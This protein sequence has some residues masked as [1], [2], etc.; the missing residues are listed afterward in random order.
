MTELP[1]GFRASGLA[2]GIKRNGAADLGLIALE[3]ARPAAA[4]FTTNALLGAHVPV[5]RE[6]LASSGGLVRAILVNSGNANCA[7]GAEGLDDAILC[8]ATVA[9]RLGCPVEQVLPIS[10]G[11]IGARL[12]TD[13]ITTA[14]PRLVD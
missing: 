6:H 10:T 3:E 5:C 13:R 1:S 4:V 7:V 11:V 8:A 9:E 12:P 2:S 14:I